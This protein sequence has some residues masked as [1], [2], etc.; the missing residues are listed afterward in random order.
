MSACAAPHYIRKRE[1]ERE[2][3]SIA[4]VPSVA[5]QEEEE[6]DVVAVVVVVVVRSSRR[7]ERKGQSDF[8]TKQHAEV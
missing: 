3:D 8:I 4:S 7:K 2:R 6:E 1:R 5:L